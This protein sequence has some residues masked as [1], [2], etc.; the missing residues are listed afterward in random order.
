MPAIR[1]LPISVSFY[2]SISLRRLLIF[3]MRSIH[4]PRYLMS[5]K[6]LTRPVQEAQAIEQC[7]KRDQL[8]IKSPQHR[9]VLVVG[10]KFIAS[11]GIYRGAGCTGQVVIVLLMP[12]FSF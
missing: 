3:R 12:G 6:A 2:Q 1:A 7:H 8:S 4:R 5:R 11:R 10:V 9:P